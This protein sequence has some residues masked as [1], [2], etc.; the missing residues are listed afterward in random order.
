MLGGVGSQE[1]RSVVARRVWVDGEQDGGE[2][3]G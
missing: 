3:V 1:S 2:R